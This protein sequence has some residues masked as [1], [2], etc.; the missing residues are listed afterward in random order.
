MYIYIAEEPYT[1]SRPLYSDTKCF[2]NFPGMSSGREYFFNSN[3]IYPARIQGED[4]W[5]CILPL[6]QRRPFYTEAADHTVATATT[7]QK[8]SSSLNTSTSISP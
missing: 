3:P 7:N 1:A 5:E 6:K 4:N 2:S 8:L